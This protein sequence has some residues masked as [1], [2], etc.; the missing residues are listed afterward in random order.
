MMVHSTTGICHITVH[1]QALGDSKHIIKYKQ[2]VTSTGPHLQALGWPL[3]HHARLI[4]APASLSQPPSQPRLLLPAQQRSQASS[5]VG[6]QLRGSTDAQA[7]QRRR[8][9]TQACV[10]VEGKQQ[11]LVLGMGWGG[12]NMT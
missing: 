12:R 1:L 3:V 10:A 9:T 8:D 11:V 6:L 5:R 2:A 7:Q 4:P